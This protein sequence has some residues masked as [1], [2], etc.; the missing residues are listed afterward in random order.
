MPRAVVRE[1]TGRAPEGAGLCRALGH[2][3]LGVATN[4]TP[5]AP[6][7]ARGHTGRM[8][9]AGWA[10]A[11][12]V[13]ACACVCWRVFGFRRLYPGR[14]QVLVLACGGAR[15][16]L[17]EVSV[18]VLCFVCPA[19]LAA[20]PALEC[21]CWDSSL[22]WAGWAVFVSRLCSAPSVVPGMSQIPRTHRSLCF[23]IHLKE[24]DVRSC[25]EIALYQ[26]SLSC[27]HLFLA[28]NVALGT[29]PRPSAAAQTL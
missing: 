9:E 25:W 6:Q 4:P 27:C 18:S 19:S 28:S 20:A 23:N 12:C 13:P 7:G 11:C 10:V 29:P 17:L 21:W 15:P 5:R 1:R 26:S 24:G 14:G 22:G 2:C 16:W 8:L 3:G